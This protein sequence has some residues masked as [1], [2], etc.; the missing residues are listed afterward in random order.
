MTLDAGARIHFSAGEAPRLTVGGKYIRSSE[1]RNGE[2]P[3]KSPGLGDA[4]S[5]DPTRVGRMDEV[6]RLLRPWP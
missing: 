5:P 4:A 1:V 6:E 2:Q 3:M